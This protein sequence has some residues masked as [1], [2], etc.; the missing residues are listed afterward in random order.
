MPNALPETSAVPR[1]SIA[2]TALVGQHVKS[3]AQL[4]TTRIEGLQAPRAISA[5]QPSMTV[6]MG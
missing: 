2:L 3:E 5:A 4:F 1:S 6:V